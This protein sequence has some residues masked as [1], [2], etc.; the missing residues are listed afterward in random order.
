M[1][2]GRDQSHELRDREK[3]RDGVGEV[4][5]GE[6]MERGRGRGRRRRRRR[7]VEHIMSSGVT[8]TAWMGDF[9]ALLPCPS[10]DGLAISPLAFTYWSNEIIVVLVGTCAPIIGGAMNAA[11]QETRSRKQEAGNK[12]R[13]NHL[14]FPFGLRAGVMGILLTAVS[15]AR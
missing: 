2:D 6:G 7:R 1:E 12:A 10:N 3:A 9:L 13:I 15:P 11:K 5:Q 14:P 4:R 8:R